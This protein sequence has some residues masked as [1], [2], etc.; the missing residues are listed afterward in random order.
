MN[1][2]IKAI[3]VVGALAACYAYVVAMQHAKADTIKE[4]LQ[5]L[6]DDNIPGTTNFEIDYVEVPYM[7]VLPL[8]ALP[9]FSGYFSIVRNHNGKL[10]QCNAIFDYEYRGVGDKFYMRIQQAQVAALTTCQ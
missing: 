3:V 7:A 8:I 5:A 10:T 6:V 1:G 9:Q 2:L 4:G